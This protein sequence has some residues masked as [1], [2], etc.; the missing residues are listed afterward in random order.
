MILDRDLYPYKGGKRYLATKPFF[1]GKQY[2]P[3]NF[4]RPL[5][6]PNHHQHIGLLVNPS[7]YPSDRYIYHVPHLDSGWF[8]PLLVLPH[9]GIQPHN[10]APLTSLTPD[11]MPLPPSK[12]PIIPLDRFQE[13]YTDN[14]IQYLNHRYNARTAY[15]ASLLGLPADT[16]TIPPD[17]HGIMYWYPTRRWLDNVTGGY[18]FIPYDQLPLLIQ[19]LKHPYSLSRTPPYLTTPNPDDRT[20]HYP[21]NYIQTHLTPTHYPDPANSN[22]WAPN[23]HPTHLTPYDR[24]LIAS[25]QSQH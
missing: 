24:P 21:H 3:R 20:T 17:D 13:S 22:Q 15:Y 14:A 2:T 23:I 4:I 5:L 8:P 10:L 12:A 18:E 7:P 1:N 25:P 19:S 16:P 9:L 11:P 6:F